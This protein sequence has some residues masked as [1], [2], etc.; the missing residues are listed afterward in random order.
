MLLLINMQFFTAKVCT[1]ILVVTETFTQAEKRREQVLRQQYP[2]SQLLSTHHPNE[3]N[4]DATNTGISTSS[5]SRRSS[6]STQTRTVDLP[7]AYQH[8]LRTL[9]SHRQDTT[10]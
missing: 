9:V 10:G 3:T 7:L 8:R 5:A 6:S 2:Y 1:H 4:P